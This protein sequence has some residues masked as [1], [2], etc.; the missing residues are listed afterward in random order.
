MSRAMKTER[1]PIMFDA[2]LLSRL[3]AYSF[4]NCIRSRAETI[5]RLIES[6]ISEPETQKA[7]AQA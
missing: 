6:G 4:K 3:D 7:D 2:E 1:V 5:R